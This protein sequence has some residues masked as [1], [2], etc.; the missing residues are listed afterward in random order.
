MKLTLY[1]LTVIKDK[2]P[3]LFFIRRACTCHRSMELAL[4]RRTIWAI[5]GK[6]NISGVVLF[7]H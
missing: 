1:R 3:L 4:R 7:L 5:W 6:K 2:Q